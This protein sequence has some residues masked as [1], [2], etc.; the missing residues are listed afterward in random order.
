VDL[1][2][3]RERLPR[4]LSLASDVHED[5]AV[6]RFDIVAGDTFAALLMSSNVDTPQAFIA[7]A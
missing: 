2:G 4:H 3:P 1:V 6:A 7:L 5:R